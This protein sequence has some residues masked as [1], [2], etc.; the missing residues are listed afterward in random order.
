ML[1]R[2][3][4]NSAFNG[5]IINLAKGKQC[6]T[7]LIHMQAFFHSN[8]LGEKHNGLMNDCDIVIIDKTNPAEP[9][10]RETYWIIRLI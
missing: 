9:T 10:I 2:R 7:K 5:I 3:R 8:F 1:V 4:I 6:P